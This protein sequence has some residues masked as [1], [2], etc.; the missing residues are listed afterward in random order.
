MS[1]TKKS[2]CDATPLQECLLANSN[3][4]EKCLKEWD[5]FQQ[6]CREKKKQADLTTCK[7]CQ[8][9]AAAATTTTTNDCS[10]ETSVP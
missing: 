2:P 10:P 5:A 4:R 3:N 9:A 8:V 6:Q 7:P 1:L